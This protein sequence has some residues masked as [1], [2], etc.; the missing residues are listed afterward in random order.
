MAKQSN[1]FPWSWRLLAASFFPQDG[2]LLIRWNS[3]KTSL[4]EVSVASDI[5]GESL[6]ASST[7]KASWW[8]RGYSFEYSLLYWTKQTASCLS[9]SQER[10]ESA[11]WREIT[12][13]ARCFCGQTPRNWSALPHLREQLCRSENRLHDD[14]RRPIGHTVTCLECHTS[15]LVPLNAHPRSE[16]SS[17]RETYCKRFQQQSKEERPNRKTT[18]EQRRTESKKRNSSTTSTTLPRCTTIKTLDTMKV[19]N[20][21]LFETLADIFIKKWTSSYLQREVSRNQQ[22]VKLSIE[23]RH[24]IFLF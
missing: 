17:T 1:I 13:Q 10:I 4:L 22:W 8:K 12:Q 6:W 11:S 5:V 23:W 21:D 3:S 7:R 24:T 20:S 9:E 18:R 15:S 16:C 2:F 19:N 14:H